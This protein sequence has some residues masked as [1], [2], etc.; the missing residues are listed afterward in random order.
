MPFGEEPIDS[1]QVLFNEMFLSSVNDKNERGGLKIFPNPA[2][3]L[4]TIQLEDLQ[5]V[6][7]AS[8]YDNKGVLISN[9]KLESSY[10]IEFDLSHLPGGQYWVKLESARG[11]INKSFIKK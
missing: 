6:K 8:I 1:L 11:V 9:L 4:L 7:S 10:K 5:S 2:N 3:D